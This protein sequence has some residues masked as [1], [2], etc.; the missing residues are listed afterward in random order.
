MI[1][2]LLPLQLETKFEPPD[3]PVRQVW[4]LWL[5]VIPQP[6]SVDE[7]AASVTEQELTAVT[8]FRRALGRGGTLTPDWFGTPRHRDA[9]SG[10]A[11]AVGPARAVWLA[12]NTGAARTGGVL[13]AIALADLPDAPPS[14]RGLPARLQVAVWTYA[15]GVEDSV[16]VGSLPQG[17][18]PEIAPDL[19]L[20]ALDDREAFFAHW[21]TNWD[22]AVRVGLGGIFEL[23]FGVDPS[24]LGGVTVWGL[25]D[26]PAGALFDAHIQTGALA[27]VP[28]GAATNTVE[29]RPTAT[30]TSTATG[31]P[32][33]DGAA[34]E[35]AWW[36]ALLRRVAGASTSLDGLVERYVTGAAVPSIAR[37]RAR[38]AVL[39]EVAVDEDLLA[40]FAPTDPDAV[41]AVRGDL[42]T[43]TALAPVLMQALW[44]VLWGAFAHDEWEG[45]VDL[46]TLSAWTLRHV[47]PEGPLPSVR[48]GDEPYALLPITSLDAAER[49]PEEPAG[50]RDM[51]RQTRRMLHA[52]VRPDGTVRGAHRHR[53]AD[54][55]A[56]GGSS[57]AFGFSRAVRANLL[58]NA[59]DL[60]DLLRSRRDELLSALGLG[61]VIPDPLLDGLTGA[62]AITM[63]LVQPRLSTFWGWEHEFW[64]V[65]LPALLD[66]M[67]EAPQTLTPSNSPVDAL[68]DVFGKGVL[69]VGDTGNGQA[70]RPL[71]LLA[72]SVLARLLVQSSMT[73]AEWRIQGDP[74]IEPARGLGAEAWR[75]ALLQVAQWIDPG[76]GSAPIEW[77]DL[78]EW[79]RVETGE[80]Y[81]IL[82]GSRYLP[83]F[84]SPTIGPD[85]LGRLERALGATL[86]TFA[87]RIDPWVT[88]FAYKRLRDATAAGDPDRVLGA[89]GWV[90]GPFDGVP[91]PTE[92][93]LLHTPSQGQTLVATLA[94]D[95]FLHNLHAGHLNERGETPWSLALTGSATRVAYD[96][97]AELRDGHHPYDVLGR[98]VERIVTTT[99]PSPYQAAID[100]R[101]TYP[102][103]PSHPDP[104]HVCHG[105]NA[106]RGLLAGGP[107]AAGLDAETV[108]ELKELLAG[109]EALGDLTLLDGALASA[110]RM[111]GRAA[112]AM[113]ATSGSDAF[114]EPEYPRTP[115]TGRELRTT[116]LA[117]IPWQEAA[118]SD[119][120]ARLAEPSVAALLETQLGTDWRW[121]VESEDGTTAEVTLGQLGLRPID[122]LVLSPTQL[123]G[124][125]ARARGI[126]GEASPDA[127]DERGSLFAAVVTEGEN[128]AWERVDGEVQHGQLSI[129][130]LGLAPDDAAELDPADLRDRIRVAIEARFGAGAGE[131]RPIEAPTA[132]VWTVRDGLGAQLAVGDAESLGLTAAER[133]LPLA[134]LVRRIRVAAGAPG[135]RITDPPELERARRLCGL[136]GSPATERDLGDT[137]H[138]APQAYAALRARYTALHAD[139]RAAIA[140]LR[141]AARATSTDADR[142]AAVRRAA[143]W[144]VTPDTTPADRAAF[145]A[146]VTRTAAPAGATALRELTRT[147]ADA[148]DARRKA[149]TTPARVPAVR[150]HARGLDDESVRTEGRPDGVASLA[151]A[152][153]RLAAPQG[154]L[155]VLVEW[156]REALAA[157]SALSTQDEA[158]LEEDWLTVVAPVR[159]A[160][161]AIEAWRLDAAARGGASLQLWA[162]GEDPWQ[163]DSIAQFAADAAGR[164]GFGFDVPPFFAAVG[165]AGAL[166]QERVAVGIVD[167]YAEVLPLRARDTHAAFGF[168][169]PLARAPQAILLAVAPSPDEE[170]TEDSVGVMLAELRELVVARAATP[171]DLD[172]LQPIAPSV[173]APAVSPYD[174]FDPSSRFL[175]T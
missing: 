59:P 61:E 154:R 97:V 80:E 62:S 42:P 24:N 100:L 22:E 53:Y 37:S 130:D 38:D 142:A 132:R 27:E 170:L 110:S 106:L 50:L 45:A 41:R 123:R 114:P 159:P 34:D 107:L 103:Y 55:L 175:A 70:E 149:S 3:P 5:R 135:A 28:L 143:L 125:A 108:L 165:P 11:R 158:I 18:E 47:N 1:G 113:N 35:E 57:R 167:S 16:V 17:D 87:G 147:M 162:S 169:A 2:V 134:Q 131:I 7:H 105:E 164:T 77:L 46:A 25:G 40:A 133:G 140:D 126:A 36:L 6:P 31:L 124:F 95:D 129:V 49:D 58:S 83:A 144:G 101:L 157:A 8:A 174:L 79:K 71:G 33:A 121:R 150:A 137:G 84:P 160:L 66:A 82:P 89:Y 63:P 115:A 43:E 96:I 171:D 119:G 92:S 68:A 104:R 161:A 56:R 86:D 81:P 153:S 139:L 93:G 120:A 85:L 23:P 29:G 51:L 54:L 156:D 4:R 116:V 52:Q 74:A 69:F 136:L 30:S 32:A 122:T 91:G 78:R 112:A 138:V 145:E 39:R 168:N 72:D 64:R 148:L 172:L 65:P 118:A 12:M 166:S 127:D 13:N 94:R 20:P 60:L 14:V 111:P 152:I 146:A 141:G 128:R 10:L 19:P 98:E 151:R 73:V 44:P 76:D 155:P 163:R 9:F 21:I 99:A 26:Q 48:V 117:V 15:G 102:M 75:T 173:I 88:A 90:F 67:S 109:F